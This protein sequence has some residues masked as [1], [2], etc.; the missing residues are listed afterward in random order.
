LKLTATTN[1]MENGSPAT[2]VVYISVP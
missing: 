2:A 1:A